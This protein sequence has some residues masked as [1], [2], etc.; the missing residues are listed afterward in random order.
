L[1]KNVPASESRHEQA[2]IPIPNSCDRLWLRPGEYDNG[3]EVQHES[4][5]LV[6]NTCDWMK[7]VEQRICIHGNHCTT[8]HPI[9]L[10]LG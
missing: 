6:I 3:I 8:H 1:D 4:T 7:S 9:E 2:S 5:L 10:L